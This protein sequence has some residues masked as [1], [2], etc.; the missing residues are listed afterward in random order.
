MRSTVSS[1][2]P[3]D[4]YRSSSVRHVPFDGTLSVEDGVGH[5]GDVCVFRIERGGTPIDAIELEDGEQ[6]PLRPGKSVVGCLGTRPAVKELHG[7]VPEGGISSEETG[8]SLL[9]ESGLIGEVWSAIPSFAPT[10]VSIVGFLM[11]DGEAVN[12]TDHPRLTPTSG[13]E[14]GNVP[15]ALF[16]GTSMES[17]K[18]SAVEAGVDALSASLEVG[19]GKLTGTVM[20]RDLLRFEAAGA[21]ATSDFSDVGVSCT[22]EREESIRCAETVLGHLRGKETDVV[23]AELG[24]GILTYGPRHVLESSLMEDIDVLVFSAADECGAVGG[25]DLLQ[26]RYGLEPDMIVG[27]VCDTELS[28]RLVTD[29]VGVETFSVAESRGRSTFETALERLLE[30]PGSA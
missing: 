24:G 8:L 2:L 19:A 10:R 12:V 13:P 26:E 14:P 20:R 16:C 1:E 21:A 27:P 9:I 15:T 17:G 30:V 3:D 11:A 23:L 18:T 29:E 7:G 6:M 25:V 4:V 22:T 5:E 28:R